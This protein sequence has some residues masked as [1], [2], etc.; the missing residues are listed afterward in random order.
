[1][2]IHNGPSGFNYSREEKYARIQQR[3]EKEYQRGKQ[4]REQ[5]EE[6]LTAQRE[7]EV[8]DLEV[9]VCGI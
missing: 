9:S 2:L 7:N 4:V 1:M 8:Q 5:K 6:K 3:R